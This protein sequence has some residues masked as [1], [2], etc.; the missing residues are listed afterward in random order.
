MDT[1]YVASKPQSFNLLRLVRQT[2]IADRRKYQAQSRPLSLPRL[3]YMM[4]PNLS[5]PVFLVGAPRSGTTF[6]GRSLAALPCLSYHFEP[7]ATKAAARLVYEQQWSYRQARFFYRW[8]YSW[9]M[10]Q[11]LDADLR[12]SEKTPRNCFLIDFLAQAF[13]DAQF[14]HIIR[15]GRDA[16]LSYSKRPWLQAKQAQSSLKESGGYRFG[17]YARFWVEPDRIREFE[18]TSDIHRCIW[19]WRRHTDTACQL[20]RT[21]PSGR[22]LEIRYESL[23]TAPTTEADRLLDFLDITSRKDRALC[24]AVVEEARPNSVGQWR[25]QLSAEQIQE[26]EKEAGVLLEDLGYDLCGEGLDFERA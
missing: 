6:L 20:T 19:A 11:H 21:L 10:R 16:A 8:V 25:H 17:P 2:A 13:P 24:R 15:D 12:F 14:I 9:L 3:S 23:V 4:G 1:S 7:I 5:R 26:V 22:F 18:T